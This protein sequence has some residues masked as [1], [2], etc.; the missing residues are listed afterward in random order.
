MGRT[1]IIETEE[2]RQLRFKRY[3]DKYYSNPV[4]KQTVYEANKRTQSERF[5][6]WYLK[7]SESNTASP[8]I[9]DQG[10][11]IYYQCNN[12]ILHNYFAAQYESFTSGKPV[13]LYCMDAENDRLDWA[14][15][16]DQSFEEIMDAHAK[17]LRNKY[18]RLIFM[19]SG[20][21]D[22]HTIYNVFERN[23]IHIDEI[24]IKH[25]RDIAGD[26]YPEWHVQWMMDNCY[27]R[28]TKITPINEYDTKIRGMVVN[29]EDWIFESRGDLLKFGQSSVS[30]ATVEL[31]ERS[32]SGHNW[33]LVVGLEKPTVVY[34]NGGWYAKQNDKFVRTVMGNKNVECF[35]LDPLVNLKQSHL[36]KNTLKH[37]MNMGK[38][39]NWTVYKENTVGVAGY[40]AWATAIGRHRELTLGSSYIQKRANH[41]VFTSTLSLDAG[42][43]DYAN[44]TGEPMLAAKLKLQDPV[45]LNYVKGLYNIRGQ[46]DFYKFLNKNALL[47][48][49]QLLRPKDI[50]SKSYNLG[51]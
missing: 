10:S 42:I 23:N 44:L 1:K 28:T 38:T 12:K 22:S 19:W 33:G 50:F 4:N 7:N 24:I 49:G 35:F 8:I 5:R 29:N 14:R 34:E 27:D 17:Y 15:D 31:C 45:A 9:L 2:E 39:R 11:M 47:G 43:D 46:S 32:H 37:L 26:P 21:T 18:D 20:G 51:E 3:Q 41:S 30:S 48:E 40:T 16:P 6:R 36:A 25:S 13:T